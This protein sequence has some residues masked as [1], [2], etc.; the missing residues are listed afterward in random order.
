[1]AARLAKRVEAMQT[2]QGTL[3]ASLK[4]KVTGIDYETATDVV[5]QFVKNPIQL[6][7]SDSIFERRLVPKLVFTNC[8]AYKK[9]FGYQTPSFALLFE[10]TRGSSE[11]KSRVVEEMRRSWNQVVEYLEQLPTALK[12]QIEAFP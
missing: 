3:K 9:G 4:R 7:E 12:S 5:F 6:W 10:L 1:M 11:D 8:L 2:E